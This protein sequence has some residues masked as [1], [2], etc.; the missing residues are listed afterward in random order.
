L[1]EE[2]EQK[3]MLQIYLKSLSHLDQVKAKTSF[4][5]IRPEKETT[6]SFSELVSS[7]FTANVKGSFGGNAPV[8]AKSTEKSDDLKIRQAF[9]LQLPEF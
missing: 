7:K 9:I 2:F 6:K 1:C 4:K 8:L 5:I 3:I